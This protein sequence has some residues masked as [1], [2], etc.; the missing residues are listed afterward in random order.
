[1]EAASTGETGR[2]VAVL[3]EGPFGLIPDVSEASHLVLVAGGIAVT[4][5]W[6]LFVAAVKASK[7]SK[8]K[9]CKLVWLVRDEGLLK[10]VSESFEELIKEMDGKD[11]W[12]SCNFSIDLHVTAPSSTLSKVVQE[13]PRSEFV[14]TLAHLSSSTSLSS[15]EV[16]EQ[17]RSSDDASHK[18]MTPSSEF[19]NS[20]DEQQGGEKQRQAE[21][22]HSS[23]AHDD[24]ELTGASGLSRRRQNV[25]ALPLHNSRENEP[26]KYLKKCV[27]LSVRMLRTNEIRTTSSQA[28]LANRAPYSRTLSRSQAECPS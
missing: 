22:S 25:R 18:D 21:S 5:C 7:S 24:D 8:L 6:P 3:L 20:I 16:K 12:K 28:N 10:F 14:D 9:S 27:L 2:E 1:M 19:V 15:N 26:E 13:M 17:A 23:Q 11:D 4:F